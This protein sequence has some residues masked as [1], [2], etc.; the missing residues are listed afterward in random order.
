MSARRWSSRDACPRAMIQHERACAHTP[1]STA[2]PAA[3][4]RLHLWLDGVG[5][6]CVGRALAVVART[7]FRAPASRFPLRPPI[8]EVPA[9]LPGQSQIRVL[10]R[11]Q[12]APQRCVSLP[13][14]RSHHP[15]FD[16]TSDRSSPTGSQSRSPRVHRTQLP[17]GSRQDALVRRRTWLSRLGFVHR[18]WASSMAPV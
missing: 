6:G 5:D 8:S 7:S 12:G 1:D 11:H 17:I 16:L 13:F 3:W 2:F 4:Q 9:Y 10:Q 15:A 14:G 18:C